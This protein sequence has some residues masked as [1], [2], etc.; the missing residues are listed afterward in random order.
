MVM[1]SDGT[2][3]PCG[4]YSHLNLVFTPDSYHLPNI[5]DLS[6][7]L[8][9]CFIFSKLVL[10]KGYYQ[11]PVHEG[12]IHKRAVI[13]PFGLF[14][15][16]CG[17]RLDWGLPGS[18]FNASWMRCWRCYLDDILIARSIE[19]EHLQHLQLVLQRLQQYGLVLKME[20]CKLGRQ[21]VDFLG[22]CISAEGAPPSQGMWRWCR[23]FP[24]PRIKKSC[25]VSWA[26]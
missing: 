23:I 3:R 22:H 8:H 4:D 16:F 19:E 20:K 21:Q 5:Q 11:I 17:C 6:A 24:G 25:K 15:N 10:R 7:R 14:G 2:W 18:P 9:G 12:D 26:W 13:N 1:Q